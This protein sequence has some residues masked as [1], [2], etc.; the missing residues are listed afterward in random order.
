MI[1]WNEAG[2]LSI[3]TFGAIAIVWIFYG[4]HSR[5]DDRRI[6]IKKLQEEIENDIKN[7]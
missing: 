4:D 5:Y 6:K 2:I 1:S 7:L 3:I